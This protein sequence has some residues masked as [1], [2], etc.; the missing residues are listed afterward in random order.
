ML[1]APAPQPETRNRPGRPKLAAQVTEV[2]F[3]LPTTV[4]DLVCREAHARSV[5]LAVVI[6]EAVIHSRRV[7]GEMR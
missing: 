2:S 6:R 4:Y 7:R 5:A 3:L 1:P